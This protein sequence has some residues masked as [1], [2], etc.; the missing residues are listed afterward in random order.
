MSGSD[1]DRTAA[2]KGWCS[3]YDKNNGDA[4]DCREFQ[5]DLEKLTRCEECQHGKSL[6]DMKRSAHTPTSRAARAIFKQMTKNTGVVF[7][8]DGDTTTSVSHAVAKKEAL[9]GLKS[10]TKKKASQWFI[11][12]GKTSNLLI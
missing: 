8:R 7:S 11:M 12:R 5:V 9:A 10:T 1:D 3:G 6:H 4:C 2:G